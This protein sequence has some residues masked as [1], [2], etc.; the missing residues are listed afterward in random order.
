MV[1]ECYPRLPELAPLQG[2][3]SVRGERVLFLDADAATDIKDVA[4]LEKALDALTTDHVSINYWLSKAI[5][6]YN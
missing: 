6:V 4:R 2:C 5:I 3:L 1:G